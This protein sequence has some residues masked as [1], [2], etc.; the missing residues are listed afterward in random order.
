M[1]LLIRLT[2]MKHVSLPILTEYAINTQ[3]LRV[4]LNFI[5]GKKHYNVD[6]LYCVMPF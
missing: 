2:R 3:A 1:K 5:L 4:R 6:L